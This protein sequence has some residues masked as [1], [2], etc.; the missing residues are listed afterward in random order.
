[1]TAQNSLP[2]KSVR[3]GYDPAE[4]EAHVAELSRAATDAQQRADQLADQ[5]EQLAAADRASGGK[6]MPPAEPTFHDFGKR[7]GRIL[8][9]AEEEAE[10]MRG[11]AVAEVDSRLAEADEAAARTRSEAD[12][13]AA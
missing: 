8:A 12:A 7:I 4:V 11:A 10:E 6:P 5:V 3:H 2:F 9:M 13:Y 1:M